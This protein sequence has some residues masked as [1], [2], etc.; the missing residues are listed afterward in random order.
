M[1]KLLLKEKELKEVG[2]RDGNWKGE[3]ERIE[4]KKQR[5]KEVER[6]E[7]RGKK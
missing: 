7:S 3:T 5:N 4:W 6:K 1:E 2:E